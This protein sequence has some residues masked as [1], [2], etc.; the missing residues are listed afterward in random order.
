MLVQTTKPRTVNRDIARTFAAFSLAS[1]RSFHSFQKNAHTHARW[2]CAY[3]HKQYY[4]QRIEVC[5]A[6]GVLLFEELNV[7]KKTWPFL[8][9]NNQRRGNVPDRFLR[10]SR[11]IAL[12]FLFSCLLHYFLLYVHARSTMALVESVSRFR[13]FLLMHLRFKA[14]S[15]SFVIVGMANCR[16]LVIH[17]KSV[18]SV[19]KI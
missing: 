19:S 11:S 15:H 7:D 9:D 14:V 2:M 12:P 8:I 16:R 4:Q 3:V 13:Y 5:L 17:D 18:Q 6:Q 10:Y 1:I